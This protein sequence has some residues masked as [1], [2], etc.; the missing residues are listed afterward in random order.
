MHSGR[1]FSLR[2]KLYFPTVQNGP[3]T[4]SSMLFT[5]PI[6]AKQDKNIKLSNFPVKIKFHFLWDEWGLDSTQN[7]INTVSWGRAIITCQEWW[8]W[9]LLGINI[10]YKLINP[11]TWVNLV[12]SLNGEAHLHLYRLSFDMKKLEDQ[13]IQWKRSEKIKAGLFRW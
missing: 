13:R 3:H 5:F 12:A 8:D 6:K 4:L 1:F 9:V 2:Q 10:I 7:E 11:L